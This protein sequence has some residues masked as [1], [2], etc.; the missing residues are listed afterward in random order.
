MKL[1][2]KTNNKVQI[3]DQVTIKESAVK[4]TGQRGTVI[5]IL[6]TGVILDFPQDALGSELALEHRRLEHWRW[7]EIII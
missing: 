1:E 3:G 2:S 6:N 7:D 5:H 4:R